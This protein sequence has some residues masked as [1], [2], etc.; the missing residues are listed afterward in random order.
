MEHHFWIVTLRLIARVEY[1]IV[2]EMSKEGLVSGIVI[3]LGKR[4]DWGILNT[5]VLRVTKRL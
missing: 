2:D 3:L 4:L 1:W 5:V